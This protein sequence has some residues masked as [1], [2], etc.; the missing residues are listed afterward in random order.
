[1]GWGEESQTASET[2]LK[3][4]YTLRVLDRKTPMAAVASNELFQSQFRSP[5]TAGGA[6]FAIAAT[7]CVAVV[8]L[9]VGRV[10]QR[11]AIVQIDI[12][13]ERSSSSSYYGNELSR[14]SGHPCFMTA[15][16]LP[17]AHRPG[18]ATS[19]QPKT[20]SHA[21][22]TVCLDVKGTDDH[23]TLHYVVIHG[24]GPEAHVSM[25]VNDSTDTFMNL[26]LARMVKREQRP[27]QATL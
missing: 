9:T 12:I 2:N 11:P 27:E 14:A 15:L 5:H 25:F 10:V 4:L 3:E 7:R 19:G 24:M 8:S 23:N 6:L 18:S 21:Q 20:V 17:R 22:H 13:P 1:M 26:A 16:A